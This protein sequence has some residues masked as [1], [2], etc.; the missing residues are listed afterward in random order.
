MINSVV[1]DPAL[2][3]Q[4]DGSLPGRRFRFP[5]EKRPVNPRTE[6]VLGGIAGNGSVIPGMFFQRVDCCDVIRG[7]PSDGPGPIVSLTPFTGFVVAEDA[8]LNVSETRIV[9]TSFKDCV[10]NFGEAGYRFEVRN[11]SESQS[12]VP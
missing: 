9:K 4:R 10:S 3:P 8:N 12:F 1:I 7:Y 11:R 2:V 6:K 5:D